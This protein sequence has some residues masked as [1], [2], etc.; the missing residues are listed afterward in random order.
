[1]KLHVTSDKA[2]RPLGCCCTPSIW[3]AVLLIYYTWP[4]VLRY[5][6]SVSQMP[7][8]RR[9]CFG[10]WKEMACERVFVQLWLNCTALLQTNVVDADQWLD[11][12]FSFNLFLHFF[13]SSRPCK[14]RDPLCHM[15]ESRHKDCKP[16][17]AQ[18]IRVNE[19]KISFFFWEISDLHTNNR[20]NSLQNVNCHHLLTQNLIWLTFFY[21]T[22]KEKFSRMST[23]LIPY[24]ETEWWPKALKLQKITKS[25]IKV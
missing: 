8:E 22:Q 3:L 4:L 9:S 21:E 16:R 19:G 12:W 1:M 10:V 18:R 17:K 7:R 5:E 13:F 14:A 6:W 24:N 15:S 20:N 2:E 25:T 23:L 11:Q